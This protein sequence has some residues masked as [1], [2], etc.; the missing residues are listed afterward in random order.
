MQSASTMK[1]LTLAVFLPM[2]LLAACAPL[3]APRPTDTP[4]SV[5]TVET[6]LTPR[7]GLTVRGYV[8][9]ADGSGL[10]GVSI[11]RNY[12][13]YDGTVV[14][15]TDANGY[16]ES[17]FAPIPGDEMVGVWPVAAGYTFQPEYE[18][19]RHYYGAEERSLEFVASP[20]SADATPMLVCQ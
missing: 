19:W 14:A 4:L 2:I 16:F 18:R 20:G 9:L 12:A 7:P 6:P 11:C 8:R 5:P 13:S 15:T 1:A 10:A 3:P 17:A